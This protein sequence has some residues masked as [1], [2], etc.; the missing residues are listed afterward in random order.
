MTSVRLTTRLD[1]QRLLSMP[2]GAGGAHE[3]W[4][5][6]GTLWA[7]VRP[8]GGRE[9]LGDAGQVSVT[10]LRIVVR[11]LPQGHSGRPR[12]EQR[13]VDGSRVYRINSVTEADPGGRYLLCLC[14]EE[15]AT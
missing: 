12:P 14:D 5:H 13:F 7:E 3:T 10:G 1:L 9:G 8:R 11:A 6:V 2:D 15:V 4:S